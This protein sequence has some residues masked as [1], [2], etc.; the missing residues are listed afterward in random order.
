MNGKGDRFR[1][2]LKKYREGWDRIFGAK[3]RKNKCPKTK[4][5]QKKSPSPK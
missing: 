2:S 4:N 3:P 5:K 1:G